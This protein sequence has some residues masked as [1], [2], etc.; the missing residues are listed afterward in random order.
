[1]APEIVTVGQLDGMR[2]A[3]SQFLL[4]YWHDN[5]LY[6]HGVVLVAYGPKLTD[7]FTFKVRVV[8]GTTHGFES[9]TSD[10]ISVPQ[11]RRLEMAW[12][13][14]DEGKQ[15]DE[16]VE[17]YFKPLDDLM[18]AF[19]DKEKFVYYG[20]G[21]VKRSEDRPQE[22]IE[23]EPYFKV[24]VRRDQYDHLAEFGLV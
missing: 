16:L 9:F 17:A 3:F 6:R 22:L 15:I 11:D 19:L 18:A 2:L 13:A 20:R 12:R 21:Y 23:D 1:M 7:I 8:V 24:W 5:R 4:D 14:Y 10:L